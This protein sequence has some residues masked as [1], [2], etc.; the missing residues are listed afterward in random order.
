MATENMVA[1]FEKINENFEIDHSA[2][3]KSLDM[4]TE[5]FPL[6]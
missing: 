3:K 5:V 2:F 1:Y 4:A 6:H